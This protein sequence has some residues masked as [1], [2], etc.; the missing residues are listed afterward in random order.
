MNLR[1]ICETIKTQDLA[2]D[3]ELKVRNFILSRL[4]YLLGQIALC[5]L[6]YLDVNVF[7]ELK[8]CYIYITEGAIGLL[9]SLRRNFLREQKKDNELKKKKDLEA[10]KKKRTSMVVRLFKNYIY[11]KYNSDKVHCHGDT[12]DRGGG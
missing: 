2:E 3:E 8:R 9:L 12:K 11:S 4:C 1:K 7:N 5:H 6:N 10:K